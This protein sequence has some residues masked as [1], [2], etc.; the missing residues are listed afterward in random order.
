MVKFKAVCFTIFS[1]F[2][3]VSGSTIDSYTFGYMK[4]LL[5][6]LAKARKMG[7]YKNSVSFHVYFWVHQTP[8]MS[9]FV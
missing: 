9:T 3:V 1:R 5:G 8:F 4:Q 6:N 7:L 2:P